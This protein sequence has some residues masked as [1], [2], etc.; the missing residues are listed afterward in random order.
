[1]SGIMAKGQIHIS[2]Y[3]AEVQA[4]RRE[5]ILLSCLAVNG[6]SRQDGT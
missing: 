3:V 4:D 1:M 6:K 2:C 5:I